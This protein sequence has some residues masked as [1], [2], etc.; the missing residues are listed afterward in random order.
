MPLA[1]GSPGNQHIIRPGMAHLRQYLRGDCAQPPFCAI[2][3]HRITDLA[4]RRKTNSDT[5]AARIL[6]RPRRGHARTEAMAALADELAGL[7]SALHGTRSNVTASVQRRP[8]YRGAVWASQRWPGC[9]G[10]SL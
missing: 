10:L 7:V 5:G 6:R 2:A 1:R 8:L 3:Y 9:V 4:A